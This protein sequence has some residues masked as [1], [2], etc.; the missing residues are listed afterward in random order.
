MFV[1]FPF[2]LSLS[3]SADRPL[4]KFPRSLSDVR[5]LSG[6]LRQY[7]DANYAIVVVGFCAIYIFLQAFAIPGAIFLSI[8]A[9]PLFGAFRGLVIVSLVATSGSSLCYAMS[10]VLG[11]GLVEKCFPALLQRFR[12]QIARRRE[13]L[14]FYLLF[15]RI[16]PLLPNWFISVSSPILEIPYRTFAAATLLG[17][18]PANYLHVTT[19][20]QLEELGH[21]ADGDAGSPVNYKALAFLFAIA[22]LALI[23]TLLK[24]KFEAY[25]G[26]SSSA[27]PPASSLSS[28]ATQSTAIGADGP[29][30]RQLDAEY[31][32]S[33]SQSK[34]KKKVG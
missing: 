14:F 26:A 10:S 21:A 18:I 17:L 23:P 29:D 25:A 33:A 19:G 24:S 11:R 6:V 22:F 7:R 8:L 2:L 34:K 28:T 15:L 27:S 12:G 1:A 3:S 31:E 32:A 30:A 9:G 13:N 20:L 5:S 16:S 4:L